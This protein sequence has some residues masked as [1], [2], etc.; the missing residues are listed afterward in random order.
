MMMS[1]HNTSSKEIYTYVYTLT[2][3]NQNTHTNQLPSV[4]LAELAAN[5]N[6]S[7]T[8]QNTDFTFEHVYVNIYI[9]THFLFVWVYHTKPQVALISFF[10]RFG[11][12]FTQGCK[13]MRYMN[14][15]RVHIY[16]HIYAREL[17][18]CPPFFC[19]KASWLSTFFPF[20]FFFFFAHKKKKNHFPPAIGTFLVR[21]ETPFKA[22]WLSTPWPAGCPHF[23]Q[24]FKQKCGQPAG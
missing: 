18:G 1:F 16:I 11:Y 24:T 19:F 14:G 4:P 7:Q 17:V 12:V 23:L 10:V 5:K 2:L 9:H 21:F 15:D 20:F 22:S 6:H 13:D 8:K 3:T